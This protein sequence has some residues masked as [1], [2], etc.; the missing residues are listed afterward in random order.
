MATTISSFSNALSDSQHRLHPAQDI[1]AVS[2]SRLPI[3]IVGTKYDKMLFSSQDADD[4]A[5]NH[6]I[7]ARTLR[8]IAHTYGASLVYTSFPHST[9]VR[10]R[11]LDIRPQEA[12][13][14]K[15]M[16]FV[17]VRCADC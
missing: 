3:V 12:R 13:T 10:I 8:Y 14:E 7:L 1:D 9:T 11:Y 6:K 5:E 17:R 15:G 16:S 4:S 2:L